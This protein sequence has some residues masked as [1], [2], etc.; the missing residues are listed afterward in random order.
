MEIQSSTCG[1]QGNRSIAYNI[2]REGSDKSW[3]GAYYDFCEEYNCWKNTFFDA[4][5]F[6]DGYGKEYYINTYI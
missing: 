4:L 1:Q 5:S 6:P 3:K 2:N